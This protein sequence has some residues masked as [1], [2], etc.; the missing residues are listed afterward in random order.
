MPPWRRWLRAA[1]PLPLLPA[2]TSSGAG[3]TT[4]R[5]RPHAE[6]RVS[7]RR[8][9][10][11]ASCTA[12][13]DGGVNHQPPGRKP[14]SR[15]S[16]RPH[17]VQGVRCSRRPLQRPT[18]VLRR[19]RHRDASGQLHPGRGCSTAGRRPCLLMASARVAD[20]LHHR[21]RSVGRSGGAH[22]RGREPAVERPHEHAVSRPRRG[23]SGQFGDIHV[24]DRGSTN[25]TLFVWA[26][27][28]PAGSGWHRTRPVSSRRACTWRSGAFRRR[29]SRP[30]VNGAELPAHRPMGWRACRRST[31]PARLRFGS[32]RHRLV[33]VRPLTTNS[34]SRSTDRDEI[35][36]GGRRRRRPT[37]GPGAVA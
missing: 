10:R 21:P 25:G 36:V 26:P 3:R 7:R 27:D 33:R 15:R 1:T 11:T 9:R 22:R 17:R 35:V 13:P 6:P 14:R 12:P 8:G 30:C 2:R 32:A 16:V 5:A 19:V 20:G 31:A 29:S 28:R 34:E 4:R 24:V 37:D 23:A 18:A